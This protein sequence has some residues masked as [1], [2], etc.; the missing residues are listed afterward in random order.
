MMANSSSF[1]LT[2]GEYT[3]RRFQAEDANAITR[4][5][6]AV[7]GD[8]YYPADLYDSTK[9]VELNSQGRLVSIVALDAVKELVGHYA[10]ERQSLA[11]VAEASDAIVLAQHRHHHVMEE[12][13]LLLKKEAVREGL[14]G[15]V[16]YPV[17]NHLFSQMAEEHFG[18][19]PVG[20]ALGLWPRSFHNMVEPLKQRMS[21]VIYFQYL[22]APA[23]T[24]HV[25]THHGAMC[26]TISRQFGVEVQQIQAAPPTGTGEIAIEIEPA[27]QAGEIRVRT[28]GSD[29]GRAISEAKRKL[30]EGSLAKALTLELPL[31][32]P[33]TAEVCRLAELEGFYFCGVGPAFC[34][35]GD[36]LM[37]QYA[38]ED[39]DLLQV[40][41][42]S[43]FARQL[44]E[45]IGRERDRIRQFGPGGS[46]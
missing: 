32:Q 15:L 23:T 14:T 20:V 6:Q 4:L 8:T 43:P 36:A 17:T 9:I 1:E 13:R 21:F 41:I 24:R 19:H 30:C 26:S 28:V 3:I 39:T 46:T 16:G 25:V 2:I 22:H 34:A 7:Y 29:T 27:V 33:G 11:T 18:A 5:V 35:D 12:M 31:A 45:Y 44:L 42:D 37:L 10:L 38:V 40:Q